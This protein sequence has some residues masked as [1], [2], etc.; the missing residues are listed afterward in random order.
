MPPSTKENEIIPA[1]SETAARP[2]STLAGDAIKHQ[3]VALEVPVSVNGART[4]EGSDKREPF[5]ETTKTVLVFGNGAVIRLTSSVAPGQ[6]LF[7]TNEKT[8]KEVVCQVVKSKNYRNVSGYVELEFT[9]P[10]VGFWGMRFPGD[11]VG[12]Q[13][14]PPAPVA[15]R[16]AAVSGSLV[17]PRPSAPRAEESAGNIAPS[18]VPVKPAFPAPVSR[19]AQPKLSDGKFVVPAAPR[20]ETSAPPKAEAPAVP[21]PV[22]PLPSD[23]IVP[24]PL[25][26]T[27]LLSATPV[28]N[29]TPAQPTAPA[30]SPFDSP[31]ASESQASILEPPSAGSSSTL[32]ASSFSAV[33][34]G[35]PETPAVLPPPVASDPETEALKQHTSRLQQQ[36]SSLLPTETAPTLPANLVHETPASLLVEK[37]EISDAPPWVSGIAKAPEPS[38]SKLAEPAVTP[39]VVLPSSPDEEELK[40]PAWLEPLARNASAPSSTQELILRE[41]ARR[42]AE[43]DI[44]EEITDEPAASVEEQPVVEMPLPSFGDELP[45]DEERSNGESPSRSSGKGQLFAAIAA[46]ILIV[47]AAG[48]WYMN[49]QSG[50]LHASAAPAS[51]VQ[52]PAVSSPAESLQPQSLGKT[53]PQ[54]NLPAQTN[55]AEQSASSAQINS[56]TPSTPA[57]NPLSVARNGT[58]TAPARNSQPS[59]NP[60]NSGTV[61]ATSASERPVAEQVKKPILGQV[62]LATPNVAKRR[63]AQ[64]GAEADAGL[65]LG[66]DQPESNAET[67]NTGLVGGNNQPAAP[68][69]PLPVGGDVKQAK[70]ISS[71]PPSY[72]ALAKIQHV[73]GSVLIDALIDANGRVTAMKIV[74]GPSLLHQAAMDALR[75]WKYQP[76]MLDG[77]ATPMHLTV[78]IQFRLQ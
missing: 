74:S 58:S 2:T 25:D 35:K 24:P 55:S 73:S 64:N 41:K 11:R 56:A 53:A 63:T 72:P 26:S 47:A 14:V 44:T 28:V 59:S 48:W 7:L 5:S 60:A 12:P 68:E 54:T 67:L 65:A 23:S 9:E 39:G 49:Q 62:H 10:V 75:Q 13:P 20:V 32:M 22:R 50:A 66:N 8:K 42:L 1:T 51:K 71:V 36:L 33:P 27:A 3:P 19:D 45:I 18:I 16:P 78:T 70:L 52:A 37:K 30:V 15:V 34:E 46:G 6:L 38:P 31:R 29:L 21:K 77:K 61:V 69:A 57:A 76:A 43:Q 17:P 4:I 40:I